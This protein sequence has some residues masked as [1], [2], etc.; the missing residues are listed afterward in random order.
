MGNK[1]NK[2]LKDPL[3]S[4]HNNQNEQKR[5]HTHHKSLDGHY[6]VL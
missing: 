6:W 4:L 5:D 1:A 3:H 2:K